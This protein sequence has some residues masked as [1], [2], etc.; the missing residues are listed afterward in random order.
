MNA[1][2]INLARLDAVQ[3]RNLGLTGMLSASATGKGTLADPQ[4]AATLQ[5]PTLQVR[6]ASVNHVKA[7]LNVVNHRA[8]ITLDSELANAFVQARSTINLNDNYYTVATLDTKGLPLAPLI[9]LYKPVPPQFQ[10]Q[11]E[12]HASA[13]GPLK[14]RSRMEAHLVIRTL[15]AAYQSIQ[16]ANAGPIQIDYA[17][18]VAR[19]APS[20]IRG[21]GTSVRF[22]TSAAGPR[23]GRPA[24]PDGTPARTPRPARGAC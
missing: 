11:L 2:V 22:A 20:E 14:D 4:V 8:D 15:T 7:Q 9:A 6:Q 23:T 10:G 16:I 17:D 24:G 18:S 1:P 13:K 5:V 21:T 12:F 3:Q 19:I